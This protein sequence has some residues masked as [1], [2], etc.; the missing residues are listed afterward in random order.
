M[1]RLPF[2]PDQF[3]EIFAEYNRTFWPVVAAIWLS[4]V[5]LLVAARRD[6]VGR[7]RLLTF[8]LGALWA[9]NA[10]AY[11]ALLFSRINPAAWLFAALF[12]L[13]AVLLFWVG[14]R[15]RL[16]YFSPGGRTPAIA[17]GLVLYS[18][19]Y[20]FL[21]ALSREYPAMPT[22]GVP[23]PTAILTIGVLLSVRGRVPRTLAIVPAI[24]GLIGG[25]AA[26]LLAVPTD[27]VL[28][29]A[30]LLLIAVLCTP[31]RRKV[32]EPTRDIP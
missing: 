12:A 11:H 6:P 26:V 10:V 8:F 9:W 29:G 16:E 7:S 25:S 15:R 24:W 19:G 28:L 13:Q 22:F 20:P 18:L 31:E 23:C 21:S 32:P 3:F 2:S 30:A 1:W 14:A 4:S 27:Y 5:G 17:L